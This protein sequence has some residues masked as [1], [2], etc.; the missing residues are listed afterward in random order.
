MAEEVVA[1]AAVG[2]AMRKRKWCMAFL[3]ISSYLVRRS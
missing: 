3:Y 2:G 1:A